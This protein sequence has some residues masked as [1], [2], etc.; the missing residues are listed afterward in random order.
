MGKS[1]Q[2]RHKLKHP[3]P[4][5]IPALTLPR[6]TVRSTRRTFYTGL[7]VVLLIFLILATL[8][9]LV[10][11]ITQGED[12][13][14]HYRYISF[15]AQTTRLPQNAAERQQAWYRADWPP[16][17]H[18]LV[19]WAVSP[20][21]TT[22]PPFKDVGESPRRRL[23]GEIFYPRLIIYTEDATWPWQ[24]GI[25]AWHLGRFIS[26]VFSAGALIF[27]Y[28]TVLEI[29]RGS[30]EA[31]K[32][33]SET[34]ESKAI[35]P[36][37]HFSSPL[38]APLLALAA[39]ALLAFTP[40][41]LFTS[42][43][44][45]DD[46]LFILL[47]AIFIWLLLRAARGDK[48][49]WLYALIGLVLGLS[50]VT[51]YSTGLLPLAIIPVVIWRARHAGWSW[52]RAAGRVALTWLFTLIGASWWFGWI[53]YYFNT[54]KTDGL[55]F[56]LLKPLLASGPDVSMRRIFAGFGGGEFAGPERP[57]AI[58]AGTFW[59]WLTYFF[60]TFWGVPVLEHDPFFPWGY[61]IVLFFCLLALVGLW[62]LRRTAT[63]EGRV[64]LGLLALV[65]ALLLPFPILR[66]FLTR[67]I[68]E[69]GQGRHLL[70]PAAQAIPILL[71]LGWA[72]LAKKIEDRRL[73]IEDSKQSGSGNRFSVP[74]SL[75]P[76]PYP[77]STILIFLPSLLLLLWS[78]FQLGYMALTYPAP[79]PVRTT[80]FDSASIPQPLKHNFGEA[81]QLLGYDFAPD[82]E[83]S[84][85]N[86]TLFWKS[87]KPVDENYRV[88]VQLVDNAG[89]PRFTWLSHPLNGRYPT[90]AWDKGDVIRDTLPLPLAGVPANLYDLQLNLLR[91]AEDTPLAGEPFQFIQ[92]PLTAQPPIPHSAS[93]GG[94]VDY[95][96]W[97]SDAPARPRQTLPLSWSYAGASAAAQSS[98]PGFQS[99]APKPAWA[100]V[101]PDNV[102][103]LPQATGD[104][105][106]I[107]I[108]GPDWPSGPYRLQLDTGKD[109]YQTESLLTVA[110]DPRLFALPTLP[111][112][113]TPVE[114]NFANQIKLLGYV[115]PTR[116]VEPGGGL[117]LTLYWQSL[118]P[119]LGEYVV[120]DKLLDQNQQVYGGYDRLPR[121]YYSPILW[122]EGEIV[123]DGFAVPVTPDAP[124]GVYN[125]HVGL[126][127]LKSG[128][129]LSLPLIQ[130][131]QQSGVTSVMIGP[132][133]VGGPP[134]GVT[135]TNPEPQIKLNQSL[136]NQI[137]LLG[138]DLENC[139]QLIVNCQLSMRFYW[140]ADGV[141]GADYTTFLHLRDTS[142]KNV[143][144]K[145]SPPASGRYP[146]SLWDAGEVIV[147][148]VTLPLGEV[149]PG[150]Y[151]PVVG[152]YNLATGERL[153]VPGNPANEIALEPVER[154]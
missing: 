33:G 26:I 2:S 39:T 137:T 146:T 68:L 29:C 83:Q 134:P 138:Y 63:P 125:L 71:I 65:I 67:N 132:L 11:P 28:L 147:D 119:V 72:A 93:L 89:W 113:W 55:F 7:G 6:P 135:L 150:R 143:A 152:L 25:L 108:V 101:G 32:R 3:S 130:D 45:G 74:Y 109:S 97:I 1:A 31:K 66:F 23:V 88:Q 124:P 46:S 126:Y 35:A 16:L 90:R 50:I 84:I 131:N 19:G 123:E 120:F 78:L 9:S 104:A 111:E 79:L 34:Q 62:Q 106:A 37:P 38:P 73:K 82:A 99:P 41:F 30:E 117:P 149:A 102:P 127:S 8:Y 69:T 42:A 96:L 107:F 40:R 95:R 48:R 24:D 154:P 105:T 141:P 12:E 13:L 112:G 129:S 54:I 5:P 17:Y 115:L 128:S 53:G 86:L 14:A 52:S 151:R 92:I 20:L 57:A 70:Y 139:Q 142:N 51:K 118:A 100:L 85:V 81:I 4:R 76:I 15:I 122:A 116:R 87:L 58:A 114:A 77:L 43:M 153:A 80:T 64:M 110:N 133:K 60:Q 49:W 47:S 140:R 75:S 145:D 103:R 21:D 136:G 94:A 44:L 22:R 27:T 56:G 98:L 10:V 121:E 91:E 59:G 144:Q 61:L 18:L 148:E 36:S